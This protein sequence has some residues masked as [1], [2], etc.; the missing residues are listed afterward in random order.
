MDGKI[1][2]LF[3]KGS[4]LRQMWYGGYEDFDGANG[5]A[6]KKYINIPIKIVP[7]EYAQYLIEIDDIN[8]SVY[9]VERTLKAQSAIASEFWSLVRS[10]G[11]DIRVFDHLFRQLWFWVEEFDYTNKK[12]KIWVRLLENSKELNIAFGNEKAS[13]SSYKDGE[14]T[15]EFFDDFITDTI[16]SGKWQVVAGTWNVETENSLIWNDD[17][18][19]A[20]IKSQF[21][22]VGNF[23]YE[24][25]MRHDE[26]GTYSW[27]GIEIKS[28]NTD[29]STYDQGYMVLHYGD[30]GKV[31]ILRADSGSLT[32]LASAT[33]SISQGVWFILKVIYVDGTIKAYIND[34][35]IT[36]ATDNTYQSGEVIRIWNNDAAQ[37]TS[38]DYIRV[39]KLADPATFDTPRILEF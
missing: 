12:A 9:N 17:T 26:V 14:N 33:K 36:Q 2:S 22:D 7:S 28:P 20:R 13:E 3:R 32:E 35:L 23:V 4:L 30:T 29:Y 6:W 24:L 27:A 18:E 34:E 21:N 39:F 10:D 38:Y 31:R 37:K 5:G 8:V 15:F 16:A 19:F 25:K 11:N 1:L